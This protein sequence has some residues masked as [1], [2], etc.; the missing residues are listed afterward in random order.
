MEMLERKGAVLAL[1]IAVLTI[2]VMTNRRSGE[3]GKSIIQGKD[4]VDFSIG[5][6]IVI[7]VFII[8][9]IVRFIML[10][11]CL[12]V[13]ILLVIIIIIFITLFIDIIIFITSYYFLSIK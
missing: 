4:D 9:T 2:V 6:I 5:N 10:Y 11:Y 8:A 1:V 7:V 3:L 13:V 12:F